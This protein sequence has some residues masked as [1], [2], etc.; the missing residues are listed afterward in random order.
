M[1]TQFQKARCAKG[2]AQSVA[3]GAIVVLRHL[4]HVEARRAEEAEDGFEEVDVATA[5]SAAEVRVGTCKRGR[6][7]RT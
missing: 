6:D 7:A 1:K 3:K 4:P 2:A 5:C